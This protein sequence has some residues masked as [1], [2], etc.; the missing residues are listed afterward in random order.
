MGRRTKRKKKSGGKLM[1]LLQRHPDIT[2]TTL[3]GKSTRSGF[4]I[5]AELTDGE[6]FCW[7]LTVKP[8]HSNEL[9]FFV[10]NRARSDKC[11]FNAFCPT[12]IS[13]SK[14]FVEYKLDEEKKQQIMENYQP[15]PNDNTVPG[16][17]YQ[18]GSPQL[19]EAEY[20]GGVVVATASTLF[21]GLFN[22]YY[23]IKCLVANAKGQ[24]IT[25]D[26]HCP[27]SKTFMED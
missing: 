4:L 21:S 24:L 20:D 6:N 3:D 17:Y 5:N 11:R 16:F 23:S 18:W 27:F 7:V 26:G 14:P 22:D 8:Y 19:G 13:I 9:E 10:M 2:L 1:L 12:L 15:G 25:I